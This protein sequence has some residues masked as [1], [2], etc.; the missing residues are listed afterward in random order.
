MFMDD[1]T[2]NEIQEQQRRQAEELQMQQAQI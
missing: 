1:T 2:R